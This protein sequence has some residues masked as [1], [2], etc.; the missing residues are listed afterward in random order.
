MDVSLTP[1]AP[2]GRHVRA[3]EARGPRAGAVVEGALVI[4]TRTLRELH[5]E[6]LSCREIGRRVGL[7]KT[8]VHRRL[9]RVGVV[10]RKNV[11]ERFDATTVARA[12]EL[13]RRGHGLLRVRRFLQLRS[14]NAAAR[15]L[16][17]AGVE[18]RENPYESRD[19]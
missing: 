17:A 18:I 5:A 19:L 7:D 10:R 4:P 9:A 16:R 13:Y 6:G 14:S 11:L 15:V 1:A 12:A 3:A 2:A 8:A